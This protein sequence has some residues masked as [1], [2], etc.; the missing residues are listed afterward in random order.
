MTDIYCFAYV[1]DAPSAAVAHK[2]LSTQNA[3]LDRRLIFRN[4]FPAVMRGFGA[5]KNR[6]EAFLN[7]AKAGSHIFILTDLDTAECP[8][9]LIRD[10]F[11]IPQGTPVN[12]PSQC[13]FRVAVK[14]V[15]SWILADHAAWAEYIGIS[16]TNFTN[17]PDQLDNPKEYL[18]NVIRRK[19]KAKIH[20]E[21]LPKGAAHIGPKYNDVL[22]DFVESSWTP[23][24]AAKNSPSL[25]R[26]LRALMKV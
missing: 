6:C 11:S 24:R 12:L 20:R 26:A 22:C 25:D 17:Y 15:E 8:C 18:L 21:M 10:W 16:A 4:G 1:E 9:A 7:M 23:E 19:G 2:L 13:I 3:L 14:E 5:I